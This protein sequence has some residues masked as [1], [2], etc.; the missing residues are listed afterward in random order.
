VNPFLISTVAFACFISAACIGMVLQ[1]GVGPV[2]I[3]LAAR[4]GARGAVLVLGLVAA[5]MIALLLG[6]L[7]SGFDVAGATVKQ[8]SADVTE[9]DHALRG[10]GPPAAPARR[11]LLDFA[12]RVVGDTWPNSRPP[13]RLDA[14]DSETLLGQVENAMVDLPGDQA[15]RARQMLR[16]VVETRWAMLEVAGPSVPLGMIVVVV[17]WVTLAFGGL[18]LSRRV[19]LPLVAMT[20]LAATALA[21]A[22]FFV[23]EYDEPFTGMIVVSTEPMD[24]AI[25]TL[26]Q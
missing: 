1:S 17:F 7:K 3:S 2:R 14:R 23:A 15:T 11:L 25:D 13:R 18:G 12:S 8:M 6:S 20:V 4:D 5:L 10:L 21:I 9:L 26:S 22:T 19:G 16:R 24:A